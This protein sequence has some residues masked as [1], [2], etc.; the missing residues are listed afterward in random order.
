MEELNPALNA[1]HPCAPFSN[2][3]MEKQEFYS[4]GHNGTYPPNTDCVLILKGK[5]P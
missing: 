3:N 5:G 1:D 4:P 2:V